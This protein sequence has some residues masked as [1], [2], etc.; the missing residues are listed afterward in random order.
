[1]DELELIAR[2]RERLARDDAR[3]S[4]GIG[5]DAAILAPMERGAVVSVD[6]VVDGVHFD[7]RWLSFADVGW[8]GYASALSDLAAMGAD[9]VAGL[10][11][12]ILPSDLSDEEVLAIVDGCA[13]AADE[14]GAPVVGGNLSRGA[15]L[16]ISTTVIGHAPEHPIA[17]SGARIGDGLFV[18]GTLGA[19][20]LG[21]ALLARG[22]RSREPF[23]TR[24]RRPR[25]RFDVALALRASATSAIDVSDGLLADLDQLC[26]AS[27][28]GAVV[29]EA[30]VPLEPG[31][32][33]LA[34]SIGEDG[35]ALALSGGEDYELLFTARDDIDPTVAT[36]IGSITERG[37]RVLRSDGS[38]RMLLHRGYRHR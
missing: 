35:I 20:A 38:E 33:E 18:T 8:R 13:R 30:L 22:D 29:E 3:I 17:R 28:V 23:V 37:V 7:R 34:A 27:G 9:P 12:M 31:H 32:S 14:L 21:R 10:L 24:W 26:E 5:D 16:S 36:R 19:A 1:V 6:V 15:Q 2:I 4:L 11:S 25:P